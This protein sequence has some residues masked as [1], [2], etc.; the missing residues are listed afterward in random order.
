MLT[1]NLN[2]LGW[3]NFERLTG[4]LMR[5]VLGPA[6]EAFGGSK[7]NGRDCIFRGRAPYPSLTE[8]WEGTWIIQVKFS[9]SDQIGAVNTEKV[10]TGTFT[11]ELASIEKRKKIAFDNYL[12]VTNVPLS[13][14]GRDSLEKLFLSKHP[15]VNFRIIDGK[16]VCDFLSMKVE[17]R[18]SFPQLLGLADLS[19]ILNNDIYQKAE[20]FLGLAKQETAAF[21]RHSHYEEALEVLSKKHFVV[22][23]GPPEVG[24]TTIAYAIAL[25]YAAIGY[26]I[27]DISGSSE[28]FFKGYNINQPALFIADDAVGSI[29]FESDL[30]EMWARDL[31]KMIIK[32]DG[33]HKLV[34]TT[35]RYILEDALART[36]INEVVSSFPEDNDVLISVDQYSY[37]E[38]AEMLYNH[39]KIRVLTELA[40]N[41]IKSAALNV[42]RSNDF[43]PLRVKQFL[44]NILPECEKA[45]MP[46]EIIA[47]QFLSYCKNPN[48]RWSKAYNNLIDNERILLISLID[49]GGIASLEELK[50]SFVARCNQMELATEFE[51]CVQKLRNSFIKEVA[52]FD[53]MTRIQFQHPSVRDMVLRRVHSDSKSKLQYIKL[54]SLS[55]VTSIVNNL[56]ENPN[57]PNLLHEVVVDTEAA[58]IELLDRIRQIGN[59]IVESSR[60]SAL[61]LNINAL[62][63]QFEKSNINEQQIRNAKEVINEIISTTCSND[64][65]NAQQTWLPSQWNVVVEGLVQILKSN[66][67]ISEGPQFW[68]SLCKIFSTKADFL[69]GIKF[70][71][72][73]RQ[74][75]PGIVHRE[76]NESIIRWYKEAKVDAIDCLQEAPSEEEQCPEP[77]FDEW[78]Q[79]SKPT[80]EVLKLLKEIDET[81]DNGLIDQIDE[82]HESIDIIEVKEDNYEPPEEDYYD[83]TISKLLDDI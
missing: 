52:Y 25:R 30:G 20:A 1:Y 72:I 73:A 46:K 61:L 38:R 77:V 24:K 82:K 21:V 6:V 15:A 62:N 37:M 83:W 65:F 58:K 64:F 68:S 27:I 22:L 60:W 67:T 12:F 45:N 39:T 23:D 80:Y 19:K 40:R 10:I 5:E 8:Q 14:K 76:L 69:D 9:N 7:D 33:K 81:Y 32:L 42:I 59:G 4:A 34:W 47:K 55:S 48:E 66:V 44:D 17:I 78:W 49:C 18:Q 16:D 70:A 43:T 63:K 13:S 56:L 50:I 41:A 35:R 26:H 3:Y 75:V 57:N 31:A 29:T 36:K 28:T 2:L 51:R 74:W 79:R 54:A 11:T 53:G 71:S